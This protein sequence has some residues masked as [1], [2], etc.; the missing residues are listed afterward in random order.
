V[1]GGRGG[2]ALNGTVSPVL[3]DGANITINR[4]EGTGSF[5]INP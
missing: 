1:Y 4:K 5:S 3:E 2:E